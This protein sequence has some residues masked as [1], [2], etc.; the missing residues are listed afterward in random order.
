[1]SPK[2]SD[3]GKTLLLISGYIPSLI[4]CSLFFVMGQKSEAS[5]CSFGEMFPLYPFS[6]EAMKIDCFCCTILHTIDI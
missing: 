4:G 6:R 5:C 1:M 3:L 2:D